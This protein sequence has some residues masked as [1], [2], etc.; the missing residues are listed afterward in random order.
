MNIK[1]RTASHSI[2][3]LRQALESG[4]LTSESLVCAQLERI[5]RFNGQLNAYVEAYPQRALGAANAADRQRAAGVNLGPLHGIPV[6]IKDLFE[7]DGKAITGGS[8]AQKPR[9]SRLTATAVQRLERAGAIIMG[10]THTVEFAFGGWGTNA[11]MGTPW[12][13]WDADVHRAP[14]GSS[15][16]SAVAVA[17]GLAS[18]ALGTDTGGSVRIPAGMCGLVGLKTTRGLISRHGLIELCPSLDSVGPITHTVE[19]AAWML[20]ALLGPDPLDPVSAKSPVFSTAAGL[21]LPV[22]GLRIWVLPQAERVHIAPGV[23]AAYDQGLEQLAALGMHLVEQPLPTSLEQCMRVAGG[24]MSAEGYASLGSL[25]ERDDLRFDPHVQRRVLSGRAID[26]AA[27]IHLH[28][29]RRVARQAMDEA[30]SNVDACAFPTNAIGSVPLNQ[31][32]EYGT[33]LALLGRFANLLNLCSVALPAGFDEQRMP[34]SMQIVGRAFAEPLVLRI[35]HAY[36]QVSD[37]HQRRPVG[38]DLSD[39]VVA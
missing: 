23:L 3:Q 33:P 11:V 15:S 26:A 7:I 30:M 29:Q 22:A 2:G 8:L 36:Q 35:A 32:D 13:P 5:E 18:A 24:L 10:K 12:N 4:A 20:D 39:R 21:N 28:N 16:G 9:I 17:G 31:V 34:V 38:W 1:D 19:D 27:Y 25:F 6:A 14:G 37:W